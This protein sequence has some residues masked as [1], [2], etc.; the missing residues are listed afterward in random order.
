MLKRFVLLWLVLFVWSGAGAS[1]L[2]PA[3]LGAQLD[4]QLARKP[5]AKARVGIYVERARDGSLVYARGADRE[6]IPASN[7]RS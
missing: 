1:A 2:E 5:L 3:S 4:R 7:R 6:L